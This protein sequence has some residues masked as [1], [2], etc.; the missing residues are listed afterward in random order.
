MNPPTAWL[1]PAGT[2]VWA[3]WTWAR[4]QS[5]EREKERERMTRFVQG[6]RVPCGR[7][8]VADG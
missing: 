1:V 8:G 5:L 2:A 4:Q 7:D 6:K 3:A